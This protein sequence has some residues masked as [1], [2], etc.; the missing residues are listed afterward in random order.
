MSMELKTQ[1]HK[2]RKKKEREDKQKNRKKNAS[3][4]RAYSK[5]IRVHI[6]LW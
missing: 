6:N 1:H 5:K 4:L 2:D 3:N